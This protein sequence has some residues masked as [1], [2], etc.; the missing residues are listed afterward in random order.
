MTDLNRYNPYPYEAVVRCDRC[1]GRAVFRHAFALISQK[2]WGYWE[3]RLWPCARATDWEG[4][5]R[6]SPGDPPPSWPG[7]VVIEQDAELH[8]WTKPAAGYRAD[9]R[10]VI[11]CDGCVGRRTHVL[12]WPA[13][14]F[15]RFELR[16]GLLWAWSRAGAQALIDLVASEERDPAAHGVDH[17]LFLRHVPTVFLGAKDR[18][19]I[20]KRLTRG[21]AD[22]EG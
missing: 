21:L 19:E 16:Q 10:G 11:Q 12:R 2:Q 3:P 14:A 7:Y 8:R 22:L 17:F 18:E 4:Q 15:Y 9:D 6:W 5:A 1:G 20:V 13:D